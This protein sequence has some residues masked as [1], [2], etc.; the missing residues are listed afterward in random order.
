[1]KKSFNVQKLLH[2]KSK[3]HEIKLIHPSSLKAFQRHQEEHDLKH[4]GLMD[5]INTNKTNQHK[6]TTFFQR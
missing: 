6:Q 3:H 4:H 1:M 2:C 5:L